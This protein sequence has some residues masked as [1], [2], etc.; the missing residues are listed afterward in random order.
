MS[1]IQMFNNGEFELHITPIGDSFQVAATGLARALGVRDANTLV[2]SIPDTEKGYGLVRT[3]GGEQTVWHLTEPGFYRAM[4]QRQ[5]ARI[6]HAAV[7]EQVERFQTWVFH[8]VL[9]S[10]RRTGGYL[11]PQASQPQIGFQYNASPPQVYSYDEVCALLRQW[12]GVSLTVN[13]L[14]RILRTGGVLKQNGSPTKKYRDWFWFTGSAYNIHSH[15]VPQVA[16]KVYETGRE[17]QDFRFIQMRLELDGVGRPPESL[18]QPL[19][20]QITP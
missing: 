1:E 13:E 20:P 7:R 4:G 9:P 3:P 17:M 14:T 8:E 5:A 18:P 15:V 11:L 2:R 6:R 16:F 10:I 19:R 12:Y